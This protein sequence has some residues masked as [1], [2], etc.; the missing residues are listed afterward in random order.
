MAKGN[1]LKTRLRD[2]VNLS[3]HIDTE[4]AAA[5]IRSNIHFRGPNVFI[6]AF[7]IIIASVGLNVNSTA[8]IIGAMLISPLMGPIIG[9]GLGLGV[10]DTRLMKDSLKNLLVMM[11]ISLMASFLYFLVTPL[12]LAN[13]T[14]LLARTN[15]TIY[16]VLIALFG[17]TAGIFEISRKEKGTVLSG[18]AIATALMPPLCTAGYG[19]ATW[20]MHYFGGALMLFLINSV[21]IILATFLVTKALRFKEVEF[22]D[23]RSAKRTRVFIGAIMLA[24]MIPSIWSAVNMI[25]ANNFAQNAAAFF[26]ENRTQGSSYIYDYTVDTKSGIITLY[27]TGGTLTAEEKNEIV[28]SADRHGIKPSQIE[29]KE[30]LTATGEDDTAEMLV[31]GIYERND[32]E[33]NKREIEIRRLETE[34]SRIRKEEIPFVQITREITSQ[35]PEIQD[36]YLSRGAFVNKDSLSENPCILVVAKTEMELDKQ[37]AD[38]LTDWLRIRLNDSTVTLINNY[39]Q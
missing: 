36:L 18:V 31:K 34:L 17:G 2:L 11:G 12:Q 5:S 32:S 16:D 38:K 3:D 14:E 35:Y 25:K 1:Y 6:L 9:M 20:N 8:V 30:H 28:A 29:Y 37:K 15:P 19:L 21:F 33:I 27:T 13:P 39:A 10:N 4:A 7:S 24:V 26:S 22:Q 23:E